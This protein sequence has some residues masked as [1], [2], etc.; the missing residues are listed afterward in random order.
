MN[1]LVVTSYFCN[2][3]Q[4]LNGETKSNNSF[5][6]SNRNNSTRKEQKREEKNENNKYR[7][8]KRRTLAQ[9]YI[10]D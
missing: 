5:G 8:P 1:F 7:A 6:N 2:T 9:L 4:K 10:F 3:R